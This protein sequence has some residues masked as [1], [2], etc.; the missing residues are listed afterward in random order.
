MRIKNS[1]FKKKNS[2]HTPAP[3]E[4]ENFSLQLFTSVQENIENIQRMYGNPSDLV[5][6]KL[7]IA[8]ISCCIIYIDGLVDSDLIN[9]KIIKNIQFHQNTIDST[10]PNTLLKD[11]TLKLL[12]VGEIKKVDTLDDVSLPVL[13]GD[14]ALFVDGVKD[15]LIISSKGSDGRSV[16]E[17]QSESVIRGPR[18]GFVEN[19][20]TNTALVRKHFR[21]PNVRVKSYKLG[22]RSK[23]DVAIMYID[24]IVHPDIVEE[25]E[26]RLKD[27]DLDDIPET[28]FIE[29]FIQD[30]IMSPFP[31][32]QHTERPDRV[33][34]AIVEGRVAIF[35]DGTPFVLL[36]PS[37]FMNFLQSPED[38]YERWAIGSLIRGLRYLGAFI[39]V[40]APALYIA[41]VSF[42][43]GMIPSKLA[44]SI[45]STREGVPF[46]AII[47]AFL[48]AIT[49]ELLREAGARLPK[50]IGQTV[51]IVGGLVIGEAAV[52][53]GI[54][55]PIMVI[56]I[57]ITAIATFALPS[58]SFGVSLRMLRFAFMI[59]AASFGFYGIVLAYIAV[60]IHL[61]NLR[62][63]GVPYTVPFAPSFYGDWKDLVV[64]SPHT[65][66]KRRPTYLMPRDTIRKK[67]KG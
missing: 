62:S 4:T 1:F 50:A 3:H 59:A 43:Q 45:A 46:P 66:M 16:E 13:S 29:E 10:Q 64:R 6:R 9:S 27:V 25:V 18:E 31:Q 47:E 34:A 56:V 67:G 14:S 32:L 21:D 7:K 20:R 53:A 28:G 49:M 33:S 40:F 38:Y 22:K 19:I 51:G 36:A 42:H 54:V 24:G 63:F 26:R 65:V 44:F 48:M 52:S 37:V 23:K 8:D 61:V 35:L 17:P 57:A 41:L 58:Y 11:L 2:N 15:A 60:N 30:S 12:S 5:I 55:S 39:S